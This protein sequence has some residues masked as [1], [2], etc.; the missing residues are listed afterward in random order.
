MKTTLIIYLQEEAIRYSTKAI[1][2]DC[3][4]KLDQTGQIK[5]AIY[6]LF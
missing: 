1:V 2:Y 5:H 6:E 4:H 3:P